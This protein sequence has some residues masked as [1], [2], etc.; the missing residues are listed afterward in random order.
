MPL[1][2]GCQQQVAVRLKIGI[3]PQG[4][5]AIDALTVLENIL[6]PA[7]LCGKPLPVRDA[8][9]WMEQLDIAHLADA[10]PAELSGGELRRM[11]IVRAL[12]QHPDYLFADEPTGDLDDEN[13][14]LVLSALHAYAHDQEKAVFIVTHESDAIQYADRC[15]RMAGGHLAAVSGR[16][17]A[18]A[19]DSADAA[20]GKEAA[21]Q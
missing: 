17:G 13:T 18:A 20:P 21:E 12:A 5:S 14:Q 2:P 9:Q 7:N 10:R 15:F 3:V 16:E 6:L 4:R 11:S 8:R 19:T 1:S